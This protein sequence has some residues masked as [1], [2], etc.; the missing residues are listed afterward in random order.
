M[1][2]RWFPAYNIFLHIYLFTLKYLHL[3]TKKMELVISC[4]YQL[5]TKLR[6]ESMVQTISLRCRVRSQKVEC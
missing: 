5:V 3:V 4:F 2:L 6:E 1:L